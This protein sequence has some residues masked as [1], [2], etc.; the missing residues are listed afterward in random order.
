MGS[1]DDD[2]IIFS[3]GSLEGV[4]MEPFAPDYM[5]SEKEL[6]P[7]CPAMFEV[8]NAVMIGAKLSV[9]LKQ[10]GHKDFAYV[11]PK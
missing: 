3:C 8:Q 1:L 2:A 10:C 9:S 11:D 4:D 6:L 5:S 7:L